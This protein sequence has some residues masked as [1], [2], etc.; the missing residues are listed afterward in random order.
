[1]ADSGVFDSV[2]LTEAVHSVLRTA[3]ALSSGTRV[4]PFNND[5]VWPE[6]QAV[7]S[8]KPRQW[9]LERETFERDVVSQYAD[10]ENGVVRELIAGTGVGKSTVMPFRIA[11]GAQVN[12]L[13]L[14]PDA[15]YALRTIKYLVPK[16][17]ADGDRV[18]AA[19]LRTSHFTDP[20]E[21]PV[22]Y[23]CD[24]D[25][26]LGHLANRP[27][28]LVDLGVEFIY[29]DESHVRSGAYDFFKLAVTV[30]IVRNC[31]VF[32]GTATAQAD[33]SM[34][35]GGVGR[36]VQKVRVADVSIEQPFSTPPRSPFHL[37][38]IQDKTLLILA[39]DTEIESW[40]RYYSSKDI[41]TYCC[42]QALGHKVENGVDEFLNTWPV[43]VLL[44]THKFRTSVTLNIDTVL[45]SGYKSVLSE[46]FANAVVSVKRVPIT[47]QEQTQACGRAGRFKHGRAFYVDVECT[48]AESA[49]SDSQAFYLFLW[50]V[51]FSVQTND[52]SIT[53]FS[54]LFPTPI[55]QLAA[56]ILL[57]CRLPP[58][59]MTPYVGDEGFFT[60][61]STVASYVL[62]SHG[63]VGGGDH[64][65]VMTDNWDEYTTGVVPYLSAP[66]KF[67][68]FIR[69]P[70]E[71]NVIPAY[72]WA[73]FKGS[74]MRAGLMRA[75]SV[76]SSASTVRRAVR[77]EVNN[78]RLSLASASSHTLW[79]SGRTEQSVSDLRRP[80]GAT[81]PLH[82]QSVTSAVT[83]SRI[84]DV[85]GLDAVHGAYA[86]SVRDS[87]P[88]VAVPR[89]HRR[90]NSVETI[91]R[92]D[93]HGWSSQVV[94]P[95]PVSPPRFDVMTRVSSGSSE[96]R[97]AIKLKQ[98][99][100][101]KAKY[102]KFYPMDLNLFDTFVQREA[103]DH[104]DRGRVAKL[105]NGKENINNMRSEAVSR[106]ERQAE[107]FL[108]V[109]RVH[110]AALSQKYQIAAN[111][112][113]SL[114]AKIQ[115]KVN[116]DAQSVE[117][118]ITETSKLLE[119]FHLESYFVGVDSRARRSSE[120]GSTTAAPD[121]NY[122]ETRAAIM[123]SLGPEYVVQ[124]LEQYIMMRVPYEKGER[125]V[126]NAWQVENL[127]ITAHHAF[128]D[129]RER[130]DGAVE[131]V[132]QSEDDD[133]V[134]FTAETCN[135]ADVTFRVATTEENV[136]VVTYDKVQ[137]T[138]VVIGDYIFRPAG[139]IAYIDTE[140]TK[141]ASGAL[142]VSVIDGAIL[143][144]YVSYF[145]RTQ[146][147]PIS[148][149]VPTDRFVSYIK[150]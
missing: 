28:V 83:G 42:Y 112:T 104:R 100:P 137:D 68:S 53:Q 27:S 118:T 66:M 98:V 121:Y 74:D 122:E 103:D 65:A 147:K 72:A 41:P 60:G 90:E 124:M 78:S 79:T 126:A 77:P 111:V 129:T 127:I 23:F 139:E 24:A 86:A 50:C 141:G 93:I 64:S 55:T 135:F 82:R 145:G 67:R 144:L 133:F 40:S 62:Y 107:Y 10:L 89:Q 94:A 140:L 52:S 15:T 149:C 2:R 132:H 80:G 92:S 33:M 30:G 5:V 26:F 35:G 58:Y 17:R 19:L 32:Y 73:L 57:H 63:G 70:K 146:S 108:S 109:I 20:P 29:L 105:L 134:V 106:R 1:M 102:N 115:I 101:V 22:V 51:V 4:F 38:N 142:V 46:D 11:V 97:K 61:W 21:G 31:K 91:P 76:I 123:L 136:Y 48:P 113:T 87:L 9:L 110:N 69:F 88:V 128:E 143:G 7:R 54:A 25:T 8:A 37:E 85:P 3:D 138:C 34:E 12:G 131:M 114:V 36:S 13:V 71:W 39:N 49:L 125:H 14:I 18:R 6:V 95:E 117:K 59:L 56:A 47:K 148:L 120:G 99:N 43:C 81:S 16:L 84:L 45:C 44:A 119:A 75:G 96:D 116:G 150:K 130:P